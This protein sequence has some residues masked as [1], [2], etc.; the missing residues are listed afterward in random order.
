MRREQRQV[1]TL[2]AKAAEAMIDLD[3][4]LDEG[5]VK[6]AIAHGGSAQALG[7]LCGQEACTEN[8]LVEDLLKDA[9]WIT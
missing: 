9:L 8:R 7:E 6:Q 2:G 5:G 3:E 4:A 1:L